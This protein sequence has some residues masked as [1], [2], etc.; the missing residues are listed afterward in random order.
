VT[1]RMVLP[2]GLAGSLVPCGVGG[3]RDDDGRHVPNGLGY[4]VAMSKLNM[5][6]DVLQRLVELGGIVWPGIVEGVKHDLLGLPPEFASLVPL[7]PVLERALISSPAV[8]CSWPCRHLASHPAVFD[9]YFPP[10][11]MR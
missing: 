3:D 1:G 8:T 6:S 5:V 9:V 4:I 10:P 7:I 11:L 2:V